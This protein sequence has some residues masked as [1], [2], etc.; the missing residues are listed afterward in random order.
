MTKTTPSFVQRGA[1]KLLRWQSRISQKLLLPFASVPKPDRWIFI[2]GCYN[3]GTSLLAKI[4]AEHPLIGGLPDEGIYFTD[5]LPYPEQFG[6]PRMWA[7]CVDDIR[8]NPEDVSQDTVERIKRQWYL[9]YPKD[10][11][12]LLEKSV[13]NAARLPFL[14]SHFQPAYFISIVR[15]GYA[16]AEGIRRRARPASW[17]N[18]EFSDS[19]PIELCVEQWCACVELISRDSKDLSRF[20]QISYEDLTAGPIA[21]TRR[22]TDFLGL[23]AI[24]PEVFERSWMVVD[25]SEPIQNMNIRSFQRLSEQDLDTIE[26]VAG[27]LL[28]KYGYAR[29]AASSQLGDTDT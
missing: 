9:S 18:A 3:S 11:P 4:L 16:V 8:L 20:I 1:A 19:Y 26:V 24:D 10:R 15:N 6:W 5:Q 28:S 29:P 13:A 25:K 17:G 22:I 14:Q 7:R 12:N 21:V 2:V 27:D 23:P